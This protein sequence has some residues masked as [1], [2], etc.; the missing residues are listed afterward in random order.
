MECRY[1]PHKRFGGSLEELEGYDE[2][3]FEAEV[4]V[5]DPVVPAGTSDCGH[6][7]QATPRI[8]H[9]HDTMEGQHPWQ[10]SIRYSGLSKPR[11]PSQN[12]SQINLCLAT[13]RLDASQR[14]SVQL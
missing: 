13:Q 5:G 14:T 4:E 1:G 8:A 2:D 3:E 10:A 7:L 9:G 11:P 6:L 12:L